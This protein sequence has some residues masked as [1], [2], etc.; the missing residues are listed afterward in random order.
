MQSLVVKGLFDLGLRHQTYLVVGESVQEATLVY[1]VHL[2][3]NITVSAAARCGDNVL[4]ERKGDEHYNC[5][6]IDCR[7]H[8]A[9]ALWNLDAIDLA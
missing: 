5:E 4:V 8:S 1:V 9:H 7:A 6:E 2:E 3:D